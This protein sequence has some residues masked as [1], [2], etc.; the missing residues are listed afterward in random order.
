LK[1]CKYIFLLL[2]LQSCGL[3][4]ISLRNGYQKAAVNPKVYAN[5]SKFDASLLDNIDTLCIY[6]EYVDNRIGKDITGPARL[7]HHSYNSVYGAYRF[8][9]NG[10]FN[11]F[12]LLKNDSAFNFT[13]F[14]PDYEGWRGVF[15]KSKD[16]IKGDLITQVS[17]SVRLENSEKYL[18]LKKTR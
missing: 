17:V 4:T 3:K 2:F 15:Y 1:K 8:Y 6:E 18:N 14:D 16:K 13:T 9:N 12:I 10:C 7:D 11:L 5:K